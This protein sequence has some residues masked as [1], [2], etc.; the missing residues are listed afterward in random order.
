MGIHIFRYTFL[1]RGS[2][3]MSQQNGR[4]ARPDWETL[5]ALVA[6]EQDPDR[7]L[8]LSKELVKAL[9]EDS[10]QRLELVTSESKK[11]PTTEDSNPKAHA[12]ARVRCPYCA[13]NG[14]F[15]EMIAQSNGAM[16]CSNCGHVT[17]PH[18][19]EYSCSCRHCGQLALFTHGH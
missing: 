14:K 19:P 17:L 12:N 8:S 15:R 7:I 10:R 6:A 1:L 16:S 18:D 5:A 2:N 11:R 3:S 13:E 4:A 9:D